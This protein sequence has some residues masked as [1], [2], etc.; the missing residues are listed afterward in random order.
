MRQFAL[1]TGANWRGDDDLRHCASCNGP[2]NITGAV[3]HWRA[4][5]SRARQHDGTVRLSA[6]GGRTRARRSASGP[7]VT[8]EQVLVLQLNVSTGA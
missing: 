7:C 2:Y 1:S 3:A 4:A 6:F 5:T 8:S